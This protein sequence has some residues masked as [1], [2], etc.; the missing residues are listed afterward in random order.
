MKPS[1]SPSKPPQTRDSKKKM[2][3]APFKGSS[4]SNLPIKN[5]FSPI[6]DSPTYYQLI[7][8]PVMTSS[9]NTSKKTTLV[10]PGTTKRI[11]NRYQNI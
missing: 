1:T 11:N 10:V 3:F 4:P 2:V 8:R 5:R 9:A 6:A 7:Q